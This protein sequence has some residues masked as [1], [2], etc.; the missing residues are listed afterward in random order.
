MEQVIAIIPNLESS[1]PLI[2]NELLLWP[3]HLHTPPYSGKLTQGLLTFAQVTVTV[4]KVL[5][6]DVLRDS[7]CHL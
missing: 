3:N 4:H 1:L 7:D 5:G 2:G 6:N